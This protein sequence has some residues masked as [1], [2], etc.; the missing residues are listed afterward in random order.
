MTPVCTDIDPDVWLDR[1]RLAHGSHASPDD[2]LCVMEAVAY[3]AG[4]PHTD[5]PACVSPVL[6]AFLRNWNDSLPDEDRQVLKPYALRVIDTAGD[7]L[8][9]IRGWLAADWLIRVHTPAWLRLA[10]LDEHADVL[11]QSEPVTAAT[12]NVVRPKAAAA[13][14]ATRAAT[15]SAAW[16]ATR[17]ATR[18]AARDAAGDAA[19]AAASHAAWDA[20]WAATRAA[21]RDAARAA[22]WAATRDAAGDAARDA[23]RDAL[24]PTTRHL[25]LSALGLLE[26]LI[27]PTKETP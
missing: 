8:D 27:D 12:I 4:E 2:G 3:L 11:E 18:A 9:E 14:D 7:G 20:A 26:Q 6:G 15:R 23:A 24:E 21:A 17:A 22:A 10:G 1:I 13:G 16:D 25:Q 5:H 19:R